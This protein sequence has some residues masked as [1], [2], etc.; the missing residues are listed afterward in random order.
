[1]V[2]AR[3]NSKQKLLVCQRIIQKNPTEQ[4]KGY[5]FSYNWQNCIFLTENWDSV[6]LQLMRCSQFLPET[7]EGNS[8]RE[9]VF[10]KDTNA[11]Y[12][13]KRRVFFKHHLDYDTKCRKTSTTTQ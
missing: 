1:M 7:I 3:K 5:C 8:W 4:Q 9:K 6:R 13:K 11:K 12:K 10:L 2:T